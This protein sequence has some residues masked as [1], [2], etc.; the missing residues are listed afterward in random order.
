MSVVRPHLEII[1]MNLVGRAIFIF[2]RIYVP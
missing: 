1:L 2:D